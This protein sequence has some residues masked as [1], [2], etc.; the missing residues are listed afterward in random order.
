MTATIN[1]EQATQAIGPRTKAIMPVHLYGHTADMAPLLE[2]CDAAGVVV[3]EDA[4]QAHGARYRGR[5]AGGLGRIAAFS[6][7]PGKNLGAYGDAGAVTTN[8]PEMAERMRLL[9]HLGMS[10]KYNHL[11]QGWNER[12]D[13]IQ[14]AAL[15]V[16]LRHLDAWNDR[17]RDHAAEYTSLLKDADVE[18]PPDEDWVEHVWHLY[19]IRSE[20]RDEIAEALH[21]ADIVYGFHY[22]IPLHVQ[23]ALRSLGHSEGDFPATEAWARKLIS[24]S[25]VP[26][27]S[28]Q[29]RSCGLPSKSPQWPPGASEGSPADTKGRSTA[30]IRSPN[31]SL[32]NSRS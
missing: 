32:V 5:R 7:Y 17:R 9:R 10:P 18:L 26:R 13:S 8:D 2:A 1:V 31:A 19:V 29:G 11:I 23:P 30:T 21:A 3:V 16:K 25:D 24:L 6:F 12:L 20:R 27:S 14:A 28:S 4:C 22:P 15:R